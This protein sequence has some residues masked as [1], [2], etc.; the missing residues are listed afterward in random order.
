MQEAQKILQHSRFFTP[1]VHFGSNILNQFPICSV[2]SQ[3]TVM[4]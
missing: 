2:C 3:Q 4:K 1:L